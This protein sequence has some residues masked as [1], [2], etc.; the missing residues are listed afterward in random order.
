MSFEQYQKIDHEEPYIYQ[1]ESNSGTLLYF[2]SRHSFD[3]G[4]PQMD[5]LD[6]RLNQFAPNIV[7]TEAFPENFDYSLNRKEAIRNSGEFG[8]TWKLSKALNIPVYSVEPEREK[9]VNYLKSQGWSDTQIILY[10]TLKQVSQSQ[11]QNVP[12]ADLLPKYLASLKQRFNLDGPVTLEAFED[13]VKDLLP[14][15]ENWKSIPQYYF[16]PGPQ[17][18][19]YFTNRIS[20]DSNI[21]RDKF[22]VTIITE[23]IQKGQ[24][25]FVIVGSAH[26]VMQEPALRTILEE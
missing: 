22:H 2:G 6:L 25:V 9:E 1:V 13:S 17:D 5:T 10:Y 8:L 21:F 26:A 11:G 20:T 4:D 24:K 12:F 15:V 14:S 18:P 16:Y 3:P 19:E 23:A 7:L